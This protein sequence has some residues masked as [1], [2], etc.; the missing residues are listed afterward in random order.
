MDKNTEKNS[1]NEEFSETNVS[2]KL[3]NKYQCSEKY[4]RSSQPSRG[5]RKSRCSENMQQFTEEH[6]F[7]SVISINL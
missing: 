5:N 4:D 7:R 2:F 6:P 1:M 3:Q